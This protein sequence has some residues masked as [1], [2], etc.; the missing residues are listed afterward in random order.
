LSNTTI[1]LGNIVSERTGSIKLEAGTNSPNGLTI[2]AISENGGLA[3]GSG[4]TADELINS[5]NGGTYKFSS[6]TGEG[7]TD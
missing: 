5:A 3:Y 6:R 4:A 2:T 1:N 7:S